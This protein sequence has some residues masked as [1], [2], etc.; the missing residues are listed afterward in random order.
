MQCF[1]VRDLV[2][3]KHVDREDDED[4]EK[5]LEPDKSIF[6]PSYSLFDPLLITPNLFFWNEA[7]F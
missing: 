7:Y 2:V 1:S 6:L 4:E 3:V 5:G